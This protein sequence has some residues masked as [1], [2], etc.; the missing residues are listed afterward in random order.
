MGDSKPT[1]V[2]FST[3]NVT[4]LWAVALLS[5]GPLVANGQVSVS[6]SENTNASQI[7]CDV[8]NWK[9]STSLPASGTVINVTAPS[10]S[11]V[12]RLVFVCTG[13]FLQRIN[14][15]DMDGFLSCNATLNNQGKRYVLKVNGLA[16]D[17][18][19]IQA[20]YIPVISTVTLEFDYGG[21]VLDT[22]YVVGTISDPTLSNP[23]LPGI[24]M[25]GGQCLTGLKARIIVN[26][27]VPPTSPPTSP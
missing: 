15:V 5:C 12:I 7:N 20:C 2:V 27:Q 6:C 1:V 22:Y 8:N 24:E 23:L 3:V 10:N 17:E 18:A 4:V 25:V 16:D 26:W 13:Q 21:N 19:T 9:D 11:F 14:L